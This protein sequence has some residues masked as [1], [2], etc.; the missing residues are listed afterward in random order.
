MIKRILGFRVT[1][2][3]IASIILVGNIVFYTW[4]AP[5]SGA[6]YAIAIHPLF[7]FMIQGLFLVGFLSW[8]Y[9]GVKD[10]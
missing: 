7:Y 4:G 9:M 1:K 2:F 10:L 8:I 3:A 5:S 6:N